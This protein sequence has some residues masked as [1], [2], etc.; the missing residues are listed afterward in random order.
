MMLLQCNGE[1]TEELSMCCD[2]AL[3]EHIKKGLVKIK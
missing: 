1:N 2:M 3:K